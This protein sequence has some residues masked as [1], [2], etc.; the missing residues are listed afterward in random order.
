LPNDRLRRHGFFVAHR[1]PLA[2]VVRR[3]VVLKVGLAAIADIEEVRKH[4]RGPA[5][6]PLPEQRSNGDAEVLAEEVEQCCLDRRQHV[7]GA[8]IDLVRLSENGAL[9]CRGHL[10]SRRLVRR[11]GLLEYVAANRAQRVVVESDRAP[12][13]CRNRLLERAADAFAARHLADAG[14]ARAVLED[15]D[16][17]CEVRRV[18][19]A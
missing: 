1:V 15:D 18:R 9:A 14:I 2:R 17:P 19:T 10:V 7:V 12:D 3:G 4:R 8:Q 6:L 16:V 5:L 11:S 13:D